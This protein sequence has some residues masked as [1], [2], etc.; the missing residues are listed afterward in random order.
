MKAVRGL[1]DRPKVGYRVS[2]DT[3]FYI[4]FHLFHL[5]SIARDRG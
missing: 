1:G 2:Y 3:Y 4:G 5:L